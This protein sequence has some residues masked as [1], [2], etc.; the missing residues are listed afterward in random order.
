[1]NKVDIKLPFDLPYDV[2]KI[3]NWVYSCLDYVFVRED[4]GRWYILDNKFGRMDGGSTLVSSLHFIYKE[5]CILK[6]AIGDI[7]ANVKVRA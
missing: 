3:N 1:M 2:Y 6:N 7:E 4:G 5:R